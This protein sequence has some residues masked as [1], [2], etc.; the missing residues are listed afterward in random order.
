MASPI[1]NKS[2]LALVKSIGSLKEIATTINEQL[3]VLGQYTFEE[4]NLLGE[5]IELKNKELS[6]LSLVFEEKERVLSVHMELDLKQKGLDMAKEL[7]EKIGNVVVPKAEYD[8]LVEKVKNNEKVF[9]DYEIELKERAEKELDQS[10]SLL[11]AEAS[12]IVAKLEAQLLAEQKMNFQTQ[13]VVTH[14]RNSL[15]EA[16]NSVV[17]VAGRSVTVSLP[18]QA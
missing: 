4:L 2:A 17:Q 16:H 15:T 10:R 12:S 7:C 9:S 3:E 13:E 5:K 6:E 18:K 1:A 8:S 11:Q 14:L